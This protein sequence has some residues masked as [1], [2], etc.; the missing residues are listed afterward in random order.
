M[1]TNKPASFQ[2]VSYVMRKKLFLGGFVFYFVLGASASLLQA[3]YIYPFEIFT[4][5][6]SYN[7]SSDLNLYVEVSDTGTSQVDF[8]FYNESL[9]NSCIAV[10]YF[11]DNPLLD[12]A[13]ITEGPGTLFSPS[14]TPGNLPS[15]HTLEPPFVTTEELSFGSEPPKP[16]NGINSGE[17][18]GITFDINGGIFANVIDELDIGTIRIGAHVIALPDGSSEA[19]IAVPEPATVALLGLGALTLLRKRRP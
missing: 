15:S 3:S 19:A 13:S 12:L 14:A 4:D 7:D 16:K 6:G 10:I 9:V 8:I 2:K 5:N 1:I 18:V 17:W 11:E